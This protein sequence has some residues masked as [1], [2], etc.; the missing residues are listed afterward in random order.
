MA[1]TKGRAMKYGRILA[2]LV[3]L[4]ALIAS[5]GP[6]SAQVAVT[7]QSPAVTK[8]APQAQT[9]CNYFQRLWNLHQ[10]Q[11][12]VLEFIKDFRVLRN[13]A[14]LVRLAEP[15]EGALYTVLTHQFVN[16]RGMGMSV[17]NRTGGSPGKPSLLLYKPSPKA[18]NV[19]DPLGADYPYEL[20]GWGYAG[21]YTPGAVP[22]AYSADP[23]TKCLQYDEWFVHERSVHPFTNWQNIPVP[24][25][26]DFPGQVLGETAP[27][28]EECTPACPGANHPRLWD[29]HIWIGKCGVPT[30]S[31]F[32]PGKPYRGF[33]PEVGVGF[34]FPQVPEG[35]GQTSGQGAP[36][37]N[38]NAPLHHHAAGSGS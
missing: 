9:G 19:L 25:V 10:E 22:P 34:F 23:L 15:R 1:N 3:G 36:A 28:P 32:N 16:I 31:M 2:V 14:D 38:P 13:E 18:K 7:G 20:V 35:G 29:I 26:E 33:D 8:R 11:K 12:R 4:F 27:G 24:P 6:V 17:V 21:L 37:V 5:A 30:V